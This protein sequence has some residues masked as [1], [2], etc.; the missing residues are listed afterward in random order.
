MPWYRNRLASY[1]SSPVGNARPERP[2]SRPGSRL[3]PA[4]YASS[5]LCALVRLLALVFLL[6]GTPTQA[7]VDPYRLYLAQRG[8]IPW[9]SLSPEEQQALKRYRGQW[10]EYSGERQQRL[11]EGAQRYMD[12]P[13]DKRREV[14]QQRREYEQLSPEERERLR[15]EYQRRRN[16]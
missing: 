16:Y 12:L 8:D 14:E 15:K 10:D 5:S 2:K 7:D 1:S 9:N 13:P 11:R 3:R 6:A 4:V